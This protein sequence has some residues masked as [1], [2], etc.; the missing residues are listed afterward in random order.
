MDRLGGP[1]GGAAGG[2]GGSAGAGAYG[3][4]TCIGDA[5]D[6]VVWLAETGAYGSVVAVLDVYCEA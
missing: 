1:G 2:A 5:R 4:R 6:D 3:S